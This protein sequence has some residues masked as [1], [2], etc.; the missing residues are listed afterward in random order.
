MKKTLI[1]TAAAAAVLCAPVAMAQT[2]P[3]AQAARAPTP[4]SN[5][6]PVIA[7][8]CVLDEQAAIGTSSAG[9]A[10]QARMQQLTQ[11]VRAEL[12]GQ[13]TPLQNDVNAF[14]TAQA[15]L[16]PEQRQQRGQALETRLQTLRRLEA[17]REQE[18]QATQVRQLNR[19]V[20]ALQ[21]I[22]SQ[23]YVA[24]NCGLMVDKS[25]VFYSNPQMDVTAQVVQQLNARLATLG[26]FERER[27]PTQA[28]PTATTPAPATRR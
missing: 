25:A 13:T 11:Q 23:T 28:S 4:P 20:E 3:A 2:Q 15:T 19:I 17:T 18:L 6:G 7:G 10:Y 21:P 9:R 27:A 14:Q 5:P 24:R 22:V 1:L 8:V 26:N 12:Q 16:T